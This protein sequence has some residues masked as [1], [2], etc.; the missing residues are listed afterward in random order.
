MGHYKGKADV[1]VLFLGIVDLLLAQAFQRLLSQPDEVRDEVD[2][3]K[4]L[5]RGLGSVHLERPPHPPKM[6]RSFRDIQ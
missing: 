5:N 2:S 3:P 1:F 6:R 4:Q